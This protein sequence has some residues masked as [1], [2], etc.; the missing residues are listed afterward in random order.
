MMAQQQ[1]VNTSD[2]PEVI[3]E[4]V[5]GDLRLMGWDRHE[6]YAKGD[7]NLSVTQ[8]G[9][10]VHVRCTGEMVLRVPE[11]AT[12]NID[13]LHGDTRIKSITGMLTINTSSG[14]LAIRHTMGVSVQASAGDVSV[15]HAAGDV[16]VGKVGG[17]L[18]IADAH[19]ITVGDVSGDLVAS[20]LQGVANVG[21]ISGDLS[22]QGVQGSAS[23][24][25]VSGSVRVAAVQG[26]VKLANVSGDVSV[27]GAQ[28]KFTAGHVSGDLNVN[29]VTVVEATAGGDASVAFGPA[30][31]S[32]SLIAGGDIKCGFTT[33][34]NAT[35]HIT[36]GSSSIAVNVPGVNQ[37]LAQ[38]EYELKLGN[39]EVAITLNAGKDVSVGRW[40]NHH[41]GGP[42][43]DFDFDF[44]FDPGDMEHMKDW[45]AYGER[46]AER[47]RQVAEHATDRARQQAEHA[48]A[49]AAE[50][51]ARATRKAEEQVRRAQEQA[52]RAERRAHFMGRRFTPEATWRPDRPFT[53]AEPPSDPVSDEERLTI[54]RM[55]EQKKITVE[56]AENLL[57]ALSGKER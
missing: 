15:K 19:A 38:H 29:G 46:I 34:A 55:L 21:N 56:Q 35:L 53:P 4:E 22:L 8:D 5:N 42:S 54:L 16:R 26:D 51:A 27:I 3:I 25:N 20:G 24:E 43:F 37:T 30:Q 39:G 33:D 7:G 45:G 2:K 28:G 57:A 18:T 1:S 49:K 17:D 41:Q 13:Q 40:E 32:S 44:D 14:D 10:Q 12:L 31:G 23:V 48:S 36:S 9:D 6:V 11:G 47:A 50:Q 52:R